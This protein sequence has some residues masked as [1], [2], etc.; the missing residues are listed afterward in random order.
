MD[1][2]NCACASV[3][4]RSVIQDVIAMPSMFVPNRSGIPDNFAIT[5]ASRYDP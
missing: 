2:I 3:D 1:Y 5:S 4:A